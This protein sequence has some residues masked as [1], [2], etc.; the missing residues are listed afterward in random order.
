MKNQK[1]N[2]KIMV[3]N[4]NQRSNF[5]GKKKLAPIIFDEINENNADIVILTEFVKLENYSQ[6]IEQ[7]ETINY[8]VMCDPR[9]SKV[10]QILIAV[11]NKIIGDNPFKIE[12]LPNIDSET[13]LFP[14]FLHVSFKYQNEKLN[15]IGTRIRIKNSSSLDF[16]E[17]KLQLDT[18]TSYLDTLG[19]AVL[20]A[21]DWN[22]G[23]FKDEETPLS[24]SGK[25]REFYSYP[26][27]RE[28]TNSI[29]FEIHT[30][31]ESTSWKNF[32]L[33]HILTKGL[34]L[35]NPMYSWNFTKRES[36]QPNT[37]GIPDHAILTATIS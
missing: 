24:Y 31:E 19:G 32:K 27:L 12:T 30:P 2:L 1:Q 9:D 15:I 13:Q 4:I 21:G 20:V 17:R 29:N 3:W 6:F 36:Y 7:L 10:N 33:D 5:R 34:N 14:N 11:K 35:I 23:Y 16:Q 28:E 8:T 22:N 37:L 26:L 18:L 25:S